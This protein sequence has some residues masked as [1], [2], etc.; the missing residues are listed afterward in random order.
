MEKTNA[1][2]TSA[3]HN[4][5]YGLYVVT[6]HDGKRDNGFIVNSINQVSN[7]PSRIAV[8][9]DKSNY[10]H[11][12]IKSTKIMNVNCLSEDAP[13][14]IFENFGF[15]SGRNVDKFKDISFNRSAN[16][17]AVLTQYVKKHFI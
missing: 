1:I 3:L 11:D 10:S 2:D 13:F 5:G 9:I 6:S 17:L 14:S 15:Q 4:I 7:K 8:S 16:G 12:V